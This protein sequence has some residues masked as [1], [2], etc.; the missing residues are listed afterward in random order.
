MKLFYFDSTI[1][2]YEFNHKYVDVLHYLEKLYNATN[3]KAILA[4]IIGSS[5]YYLTD[6]Y[7]ALEREQ[8]NFPKIDWKH[9]EGVWKRYIDVSLSNCTDE[10]VAYIA[11]Y[12]LYLDGFIIDEQYEVKAKAL[13]NK[14][15][16]IAHN[17]DILCLVEYFDANTQWHKH[18]VPNPSQESLQRLFPTDSLLDDYFKCICSHTLNKG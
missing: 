6:K 10:R 3:D 18:S 2:E 7:S 17:E 4:T 16:E 11:A 15:K 12:T 14:C 1:R 8:S 9:I 5:W 13:M